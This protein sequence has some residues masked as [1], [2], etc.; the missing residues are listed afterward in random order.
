MFPFLVS[1]FA[2]ASSLDNLEDPA[3]IENLAA[4][5]DADSK[6]ITLDGGNVTKWTDRHNG[7]YLEQTGS[8][9]LPAYNES[10]LNG[11]PSLTFDGS[12]DYLYATHTDPT[13]DNFL[14][15]ATGSKEYTM[16]F[17]INHNAGAGGQDFLLDWSTPGT[18]GQLRLF[19][20]ANGTFRALTGFQQVLGVRDVRDGESHIISCVTNRAS[21]WVIRIDGMYDAVEADPV[22]IIS[23]P[24]DQMW[25]GRHMVTQ[26]EYYNGDISEVIIY[27]R[28]LTDDEINTVEAY[29][30]NKYFNPYN[31]DDLVEVFQAVS[32]SNIATEVA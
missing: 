20:A 29:L 28:A 30:F 27:D 4:W 2:N 23:N 1:V 24:A 21:D 18:A 13:N 14:L 22:N 9:R 8:G 26:V 31:F 32:S 11:R 3:T 12:N 25:M 15:L 7:Y 5:F 16:F 6:Y 17:V 10:A 19:F